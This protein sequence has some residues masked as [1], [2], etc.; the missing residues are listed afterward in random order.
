MVAL[1]E[2]R[3]GGKGGRPPGGGKIKTTQ[4]RVNSDLADM[5]AALVAVTPD[6]S[7]AQ[8]LDPILRP[9][10][11]RRYLRYQEELEEVRQAEAATEALKARIS[12]KIASA[13]A[14]RKAWRPRGRK[15]GQ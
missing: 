9:E 15:G 13:D 8:F 5:I 11:E 7:A 3:M 14:A 2:R 4:V 10:I 1:A 12:E 6:T